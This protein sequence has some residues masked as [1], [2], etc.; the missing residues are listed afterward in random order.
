MTTRFPTFEFS[1]TRPNAIRK[2]RLKLPSSNPMMSMVLI[3]QRK[4]QKC[5]CRKTMWFFLF[6]YQELKKVSKNMTSNLNALYYGLVWSMQLSEFS[7]IM[8]HFIVSFRR[9]QNHSNYMINYIPFQSQLL[10]DLSSS[11]GKCCQ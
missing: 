2:E 11:F 5:R 3:T 7:I 10:L 4:G 9:S 8:P 6:L 1:F